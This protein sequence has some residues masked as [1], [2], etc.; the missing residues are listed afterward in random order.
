[1]R[2]DDEDMMDD[3]DDDASHGMMMTSGPR[4]AAADDS[5][6]MDRSGMFGVPSVNSMMDEEDGYDDTQAFDDEEDGGEGQL[7]DWYVSHSFSFT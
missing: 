1:M 2:S 3:D 7:P 6:I 4:Y 5:G